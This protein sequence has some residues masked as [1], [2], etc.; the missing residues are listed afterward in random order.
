MLEI[1][2]KLP[3]SF[4]DPAGFLF[5]KQGELYRQINNYYATDYEKLMHS[6]LYQQLVDSN[7]LVP[8]QEV[9]LDHALNSEQATKVIKPLKIPFIS[10]PFEWSFSQLKDAA[11]LTLTIQEKALKC[12]M[13]LKDA[14]AYNVQFYKGKPIFIDTLSFFSYQEGQPWVAYR[15]FCQHF[16]A[17][18]MLMKYRDVR[19]NQLFKNYI[20]GIPLDLASK[21][22][23]SSTF[24][25]L[26]SL[27][28]I[29][30]HA[31]MQRK[32]QSTTTKPVNKA[33]FSKIAFTHLIS[34]LKSIIENLT[35]PISTQTEW[36]DYYESNNNYT[37]QSIQEKERIIDTWIKDIQPQIVWDM[38][39][40]TGRFSLIAGRHAQQVIAWDIDTSCIESLYRKLSTANVTNVLPLLLDLTNPSPA[41]GWAHQERDSL[42][43]RA[44]AD[45]ILAL[46]LIH[47]L[48]IVNNLPLES[49]GSFFYN[50]C[51]FLIIE[52]VPKED[53]QVQK[54]FAT[55]EDVFD[56]YD[57]ENFEK[58]FANF[59]TILDKF[60]IMGTHRTLYFMKRRLI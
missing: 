43:Q 12:D 5:K 30:M 25:K 4:R 36:Y 17:P 40:N 54:L 6:G 8:H 59:F 9:H 16:L 39:A 60:P 18:L 10:Y 27:L 11:L 32:F 44:N 23:P 29:H 3:S 15:Q 19:L 41:L 7:Q 47:H 51:E 56:R 14:S 37:A 49:I 38:G 42:M 1:E 58:C 50:L 35:L 55:R 21:L 28:H 26:S 53:S 20:D 33:T 13:S 24:F 34:S 48:A 22:L 31:K 45:A 2:Q 57:I 46:G 52:F